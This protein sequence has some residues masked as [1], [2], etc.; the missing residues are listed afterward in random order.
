MINP[1]RAWNRFFFGLV[2]AKPLG[3]IRILYGLIA[4]A[5]LGFCAVDLDYWYT[6]TG[7]LRGDEAW[8]M[9]GPTQ[10]SLLHFYQDPTTVR[11]WFVAVATFAA[12]F[13]IGLRTRLMGILYYVGMLMLHNRNLVSSSGAD[14]LLLIC[15]FNLMLSPCGAAYSV[16]A[17]L[18]SRRRGTPASPVVLPWALR[19]IQIQ[20]AV[21]YMG[22]SIIKAGG[23]TWLNGT[24]LHFVFNNTEVT[25]FDVTFLNEYPVLINAM[26]Y[27]A[28]AMEFTLAFFLW[29]RACRPFM[30]YV[31]LMLH[32]GILYTINIPCFG[33][34][35]WVGYLSF[36]TP[37]EWDGLI[38]AIDVRRL[39]R[40][41]RV[42][43][44]GS[45][46]GRSS[47]AGVPAVVD[48]G[49]DRRG[50]GLRRSARDPRDGEPTARTGFGS[51]QRLIFRSGSSIV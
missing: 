16:D 5:N 23:A 12:F 50:R 45:G 33:E 2:S 27:T 40:K 34:L 3:A 8:V 6:D 32:S 21:V 20:V 4:L 46:R 29:F 39:S 47:V 43:R 17:R 11:V 51:E 25:R 41:E 37:P 31:G 35:M 1:I 48:P 38:R 44:R 36:L 24:A 13:T 30:I 28:L 9:A 18:E 19:L 42:A 14:V 22:A 26:T 49:P 7:L 10:P 15:G